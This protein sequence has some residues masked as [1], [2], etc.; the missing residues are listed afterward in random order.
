MKCG[1]M[2]LDLIPE[3]QEQI[4]LFEGVVDERKKK[5]IKALDKVNV[6]FGKDIVRYAVQGYEKKYRLRADHLSKRYT[7]NINEILEVKY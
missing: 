7:T 5:I 1:V 4:N 3:G 2:V 6:S